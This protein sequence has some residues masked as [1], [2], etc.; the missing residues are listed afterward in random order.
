MKILLGWV[1]FT[2]VLSIAIVLKAPDFMPVGEQSSELVSQLAKVEL[3]EELLGLESLDSTVLQEKHSILQQNYKSNVANAQ[4][5]TLSI[6]SLFFALVGLNLLNIL[7]IVIYGLVTRKK[8][9]F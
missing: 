9:G 2:S 7:L 1:L 6:T 8:K 5:E 4:L 3:L